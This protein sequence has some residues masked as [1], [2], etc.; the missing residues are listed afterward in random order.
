MNVHGTCAKATNAAVVR[1][2]VRFR[3][4]FHYVNKP[5]YPYYVG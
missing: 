2:M 3:R 4:N 5:A 1:N